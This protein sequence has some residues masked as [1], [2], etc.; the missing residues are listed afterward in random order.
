MSHVMEKGSA[1]PLVLIVDDDRL[2]RQVLR[3][4]LQAAGFAV[5][6]AADGEEGC[7]AALEKEPDLIL[8]DVYMPNQDGV[9]TCRILRSLPKLRTTPIIMMTARPDLR[10]AVNPFQVGADD[11]I[12]KPVDGSEIVGRIQANLAKNRSR[13]HLEEQLRERQRMEQELLKA[14]T[15]LERANEK[16]RRHDRLRAEFLN[17]AAHELRM[18]VTIVNGYCSLLLDS[19]TDNLTQEQRDYLDAA[20]ASSE[21]LVRLTNNMLDLSR[22]EAG[23]MRMQFAPQD[24]ARTIQEV[25]RDFLPLAERGGLVLDAVCREECHALFDRDQIHRVMTNLLGNAVKFT[26]SGGRIQ[27]SVVDE[28]REVQVLVEDTGQGIPRERL[29]DLFEEFVQVGTQDALR[30]TGLGLSICRKIIQTHRGRIWVESSPGEGS[31]FYFTLP[32]RD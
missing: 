5:A 25:C 28:T 27:V 23:K 15:D 32:K 21:R 26:P 31:R 30:G 24:L 18:P 17:T 16:L 9:T 7:R 11:Y 2:I 8:L 22:L 12:A 4:T 29:C 1:Q 13:Q 3:E 10:G 6:L 20:I 14:K 19:G